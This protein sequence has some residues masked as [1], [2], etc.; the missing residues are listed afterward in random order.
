MTP[1]VWVSFSMRLTLCTA[2]LARSLRFVPCCAICSSMPCGSSSQMSASGLSRRLMISGEGCD[3]GVAPFEQLGEVAGV[4]L[5]LHRCIPMQLMQKLRRG[6]QQ[7]RLGVRSR[8]SGAGSRAQGARFRAR[9]REF[10]EASVTCRLWDSLARPWAAN[11]PKTR[12]TIAPG[13]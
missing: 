9:L 2:V 4:G 1:L 10:R 7:V 8:E 6:S 12:R 11:P 5:S 3:K 13:V